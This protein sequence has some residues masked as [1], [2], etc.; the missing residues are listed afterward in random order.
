M[1]WN[2]TTKVVGGNIDSWTLTLD[3]LKFYP[4]SMRKYKRLSWTLTLDVL[5]FAS[6]S[7]TRMTDKVEP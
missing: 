4:P 1:Y 5:K 3:V 6:G 2:S 7:R